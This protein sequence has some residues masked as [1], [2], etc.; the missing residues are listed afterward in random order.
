MLAKQGGMAE[1]WAM[2]TVEGP[3][4]CTFFLPSGATWEESTVELCFL[5]PPTETG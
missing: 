4:G 5:I 2:G 3:T 1:A